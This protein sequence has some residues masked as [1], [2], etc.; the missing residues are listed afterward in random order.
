MGLWIG[1]GRKARQCYGF[2]EIAIVP[3]SVTIDP[4]DVDTHWKLGDLKFEIPVL[5][6]AMDGVVDVGFA[7]EMSKL[8]GIGVLNLEGIQTRYVDPKSA[9]EKIVSAS[10]EE[11]TNILQEI[12]EK[13]SI[14]EELIEKRIKEIKSAGAIAVVSSIP[15]RAERF[16]EIAQGAGADIFVIQSTVTTAKY[17]SKDKPSLNFKE[18]KKKI[19]I[20]LI[21]GNCVTYESALDLMN[22]GIDALLVGVGPGAACTTRGVLGIGIPQVSATADCAAARDFYYKQTGRYVSIITD[23][24]MSIG[25]D[26]CKAFASGADAVMI[27][28][29]FAKAKESPGKGYH[30]GMAT[31]HRNLPRGT[32]IYVGTTNTLEQ[33]LYGPAHL[34]DGSQNIIGALRTAMGMCGVKNIQEMQLAEL[35]IAPAI[36]TEGKIFQKAQRIGMGK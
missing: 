21:V 29:A 7:I 31:P 9:I 30:W 28:S 25:G 19:S 22:T 8:G 17:I 34:D 33:I 18:L 4:D 6:A 23:G 36:K 32:R 15:Q 20:P 3:G 27:G 35:I 2:D 13:E 5:A 10:P 12:Y 16:A 14:K 11:A 1:R 24:G 26:V